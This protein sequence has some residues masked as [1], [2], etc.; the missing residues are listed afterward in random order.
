M[1]GIIYKSKNREKK[2]YQICV[3]LGENTI[4]NCS[5][6][7]VVSTH[8]NVFFFSRVH[9]ACHRDVNGIKPGSNQK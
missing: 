4:I 7:S 2:F 6:I 1:T 3:H 8:V 9:P 5:R